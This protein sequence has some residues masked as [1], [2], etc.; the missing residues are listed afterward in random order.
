M[1]SPRYLA[2]LIRKSQEL[3]AARLHRRPAPSRRH[4]V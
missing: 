2:E 4:D 1:I 3:E